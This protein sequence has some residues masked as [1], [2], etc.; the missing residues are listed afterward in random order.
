MSE[1]V[2][3]IYDTK[4]K[5]LH[6]LLE[7]ISEGHAKEVPIDE[8]PKQ[9]EE[10]SSSIDLVN[11]FFYNFIIIKYFTFTSAKAGVTS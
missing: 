3:K 7:S 5:Y 1:W 6:P 10:S 4:L 2:S 9:V 11:I 8:P